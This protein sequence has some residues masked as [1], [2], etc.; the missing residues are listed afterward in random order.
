MCNFAMGGSKF[1]KLGLV[2][3][4][5]VLWHSDV[6]WVLKV[7][8]PGCGSDLKFCLVDVNEAFR[9]VLYAL[10]FCNMV[11]FVMGG[12]IG[13]PGNQSDWSLRVSYVGLR[14]W[15]QLHCFC[16]IVWCCEGGWVL[17]DAGW[18]FGDHCIQSLWS[19]LYL[20][21][22]WFT[23]IGIALRCRDVDHGCVVTLKV[24]LKF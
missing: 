20:T 11:A 5:G 18:S 22:L 21:C 14:V 12:G 2:K 6:L 16:A 13:D 8:L 24:I 10:A 1:C 15:L 4:F 23:Y 3:V 7:E 9:T 19:L 17:W